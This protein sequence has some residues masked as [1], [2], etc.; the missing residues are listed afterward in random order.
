[1]KQHKF[2]FLIGFFCFSG[3]LFSQSIKPKDLIGKWTM[4]TDTAIS[5]TVLTLDFK[6]D[7]LIIMTDTA[8]PKYPKI[9]SFTIYSSNDTT[10]LKTRQY[11]KSG[12][13]VIIYYSISKISFNE[14]NLRI[15]KSELK[16][17]Y[18]K[19]EMEKGHPWIFN[20]KRIE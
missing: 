5:L 2:Y 14:Y 4:S 10:I 13:S 8:R 19:L 12:G 6:N 18:G 20:L 3:E 15:L 17:F 11:Y 7:S 1:M 9:L 16:R